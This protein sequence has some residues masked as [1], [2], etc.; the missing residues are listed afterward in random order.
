MP[1][2]TLS[3]LTGTGQRA[4]HHFHN[5]DG[6][7]CFTKYHD[8]VNEDLGDHCW[9]SDCLHPN[10][11][12]LD[13][14]RAETCGSDSKTACPQYRETDVECEDCIRLHGEV[15]AELVA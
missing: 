1:G 15:A 2:P 11:E 7:S 6:T 12:D 10:Y 14:C 4:D 3:Q 8:L 9:C 5:C 13:A